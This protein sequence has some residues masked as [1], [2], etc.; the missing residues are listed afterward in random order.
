MV[1]EESFT[2]QMVR[3]GIYNDACKWLRFKHYVY[4]TRLKNLME[5]RFVQQR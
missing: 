3:D 1:V 4:D 2:T 5:E